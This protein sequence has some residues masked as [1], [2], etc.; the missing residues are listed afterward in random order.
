MALAD[1]KTARDNLETILITATTN[2]Q[3]SY[4]V[5][6]RSFSWTEYRLSLTTQIGELDKLIATRE[7]A[8]ELRTIA[9]G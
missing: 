2:P 5:G 4:S 3:L 9:L 6:G 8:V 7:G 1:L